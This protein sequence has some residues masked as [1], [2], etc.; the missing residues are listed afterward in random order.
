MSKGMFFLLWIYP[1]PNYIM[2]WIVFFAYLS[3]RSP[4][5]THEKK[6]HTL[7][8][9]LFSD[10]IDLRETFSGLIFGIYDI[11]LRIYMVLELWH[12]ID[13]MCYTI[14]YIKMS[15][16]YLQLKCAMPHKFLITRKRHTFS[17]NL[18]N[19]IDVII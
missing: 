17:G 7:Y 1:N 9:F 6:E 8:F 10:T 14:V 3:N 4:A 15:I 16:T 2:I 12:E 5:Y 11:Q 19:K 18:Q 13:T